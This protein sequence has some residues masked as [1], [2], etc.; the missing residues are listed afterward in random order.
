VKVETNR[1]GKLASNNRFL[2]NHALR[3]VKWKER[4]GCVD[5]VQRKR[6]S[7]YFKCWSY[8]PKGES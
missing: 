3:S 2:Y 1:T 5:S 4:C 8:N 7:L 6:K